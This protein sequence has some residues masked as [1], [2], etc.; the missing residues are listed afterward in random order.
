MNR[1]L[2]EPFVCYLMD[3]LDIHDL[4]GMYIFVSIYLKYPLLSRIVIFTVVI[5]DLIL[6]S[7]KTPLEVVC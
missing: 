6:S 3:D 2:Q 7:F 1:E 4:Y 5:Q